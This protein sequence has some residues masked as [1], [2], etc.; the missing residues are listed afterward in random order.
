MDKVLTFLAAEYGSAQA[1]LPTEHI[2]SA[3]RPAYR[4][5]LRRRQAC[6]SS[7]TQ[8]GWSFCAS[9]S[10]VEI[11]PGGDKRT[12]GKIEVRLPDN[13]RDKVTA[14]TIEYNIGLCIFGIFLDIHKN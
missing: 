14:E 5:R 3:G 11:P 6:L 12:K 9:R 13:Q 4:A 7:I 10:A 8:A 2:F 1:D